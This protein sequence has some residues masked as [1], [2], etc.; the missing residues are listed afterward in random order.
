MGVGG[1]VVRGETL[2]V[3]LEDGVEVAAGDGEFA[4]C[5]P[6]GAAGC[7][8]HPATKRVAKATATAK[9]LIIPVNTDARVRGI[10]KARYKGAKLMQNARS[11]TRRE[12]F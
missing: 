7:C 8:S 9:N 12:A 11:M 5:P 6:E 10:F 4:G 2:A 3:G 1:G